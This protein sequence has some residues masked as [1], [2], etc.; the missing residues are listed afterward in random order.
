MRPS[1]WLTSVDFPTPAQ[2]T[3][4]TTFCLI[5][6]EA[7]IRL[8]GCP[9]TRTIPKFR[10]LDRRLLSNFGQTSIPD[11]LR[12]K[13][14]SRNGIHEHPDGQNGFGPNDAKTRWRIVNRIN[15]IEPRRVCRAI[16]VAVSS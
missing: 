3:I 8:P 1:Q 10:N 5:D 12:I 6:Y 15:A 9:R 7:R 4:V 11:E 14:H 13:G 2:A 16:G